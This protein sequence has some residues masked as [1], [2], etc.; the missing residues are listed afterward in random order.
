MTLP[1]NLLSVP[2]FREPLPN[3]KMD[4]S[5]GEPWNWVDSHDFVSYLIENDYICKYSVADIPHDGNHGLC[6]SCQV[7]AIRKNIYKNRKE[8]K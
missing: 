4:H 7:K 6:A 3:E 2:N 8:N 1:E 5:D